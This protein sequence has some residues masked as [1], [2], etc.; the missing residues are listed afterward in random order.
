MF[1]G[2]CRR[3]IVIKIKQNLIVLIIITIGFCSVFYFRCSSTSADTNSISTDVVTVT[4]INKFVTDADIKSGTKK[5]DNSLSPVRMSHKEHEKAGV[6]CITCHHKSG[7]DERIKQCAMCH[8]GAG[9]EEL[10]HSLCIKCHVDKKKGPATCE[11]CHKD[12]N[13]KK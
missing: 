6:Q 5:T 9:S 11:G 12:Q 3:K 7:N 10:M 1:S 2:T 4:D 13:K 8:K